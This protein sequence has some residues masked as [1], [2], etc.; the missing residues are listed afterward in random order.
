MRGR[1][2]Y[3]AM[4]AAALGSIVSFGG[5]VVPLFRSERLGVVDLP[6]LPT[7]KRGKGHNKSPRV[8]RSKHSIPRQNGYPR[9][10]LNI[11]RECARRQRQMG[12]TA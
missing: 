7:H 2:G 9:S 12:V 10:E 3:L 4:M 8:R 6:V 11:S 1:P 5:R